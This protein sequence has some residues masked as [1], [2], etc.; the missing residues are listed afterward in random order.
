M[1]QKKELAKKIMSFPKEAKVFFV[2]WVLQVVVNIFTTPGKPFTKF[3]NFV[4]LIILVL[5]I[6]GFVFYITNKI[7]LFKINKCLEGYK[8]VFREEQLQ[9]ALRQANMAEE[10]FWK[11]IYGNV[12]K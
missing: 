11:Y 5:D 8:G 6:V 2:A 3:G 7:K 4:V 12:R 9:Y 1:K 10:D